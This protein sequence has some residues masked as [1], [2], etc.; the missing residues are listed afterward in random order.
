[1]KNDADRNRIRR[2]LT[3]AESGKYLV[4]Q[5]PSDVSIGISTF[6]A[7]NIAP[8]LYTSPQAAEQPL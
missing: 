6:I 7:K 3:E 2:S 1:M 8:L 4:N 5:L